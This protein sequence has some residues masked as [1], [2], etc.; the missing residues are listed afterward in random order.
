MRE[1]IDRP[2][3]DLRTR[4]ILPQEVVPVPIQRRS[5]R[6]RDEPTAAVGTDIAQNLFNASHTEGALIRTDPRLK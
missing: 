3:L 2:M 6:A 1:Q 4:R 5:D